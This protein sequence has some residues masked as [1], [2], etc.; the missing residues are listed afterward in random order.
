VNILDYIV[1]F[2]KSQS[3]EF[4]LGCYFEIDEW[5]RSGTIT[6]GYLLELQSRFNLNSNQLFG[7][8]ALLHEQLIQKTAILFNFCVQWLIH[9]RLLCTLNNKDE[10][11]FYYPNDSAFTFYLNREEQCICS[12]SRNK[13][14]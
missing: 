8:G 7:I 3:T 11:A 12:S 13:Y 9:E 1:D 10:S 4:L 14:S 5:K 2:V 6:N